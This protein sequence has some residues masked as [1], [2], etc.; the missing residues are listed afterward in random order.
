M[1]KRDSFMTD[2]SSE[3]STLP[4]TTCVNPSLATRQGS[5]AFD[6]RHACNVSIGGGGRILALKRARL[7]PLTLACVTRG[8][9][10][11]TML[12]VTT[13]TIS[14]PALHCMPV[15]IEQKPVMCGRLLG[16]GRWWIAQGHEPTWSKE[17]RV[18]VHDPSHSQA[19]HA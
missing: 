14:D 11:R 1:T 13:L 15:P 6:R 19:H 2:T 7:Q 17:G 8:I 3:P 12:V 5:A 18:V 9:L 4:L 16:M 10:I